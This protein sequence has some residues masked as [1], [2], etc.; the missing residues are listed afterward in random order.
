[1]LLDAR[2]VILPAM[3]TI[4]ILGKLFGGPH[5]VKLLRLFLFN[6]ETIFDR[7][8]IASRAKIPAERLTKEINTLVAAGVIKERAIPAKQKNGSRAKTGFE[9]TQAFPLASQIKNLLNADFIRRKHELVR[10]FKNCG[11]IKLLIVSGIFVENTDSRVDL[12]IVGETLKRNVIENIIRGIEAEVGRELVYSI[13][14][15]DDFKY[16]A[17]SSDKFIRDIF[18]YPHERIIDKMPF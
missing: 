14:E 7:N 15:T 12:V 13:M 6:P 10:R 11:K 4:D 16:R 8:S 5:R 9:L 2:F 17:N 1:M 3:H 18:D